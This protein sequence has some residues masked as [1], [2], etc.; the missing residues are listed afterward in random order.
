[1]IF[2]YRNGCNMFA[3]ALHLQSKRVDDSAYRIAYIEIEFKM[4][5][6]NKNQR[7]EYIKSRDIW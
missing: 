5:S 3:T 7:F 6:K 4:K 1:M 2:I